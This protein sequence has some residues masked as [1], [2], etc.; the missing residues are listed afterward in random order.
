MKPSI[1]PDTLRSVCRLQQLCGINKAPLQLLGWGQS[2]Q[3]RRH[4]SKRRCQHCDA[5][6]NTQ[7][8]RSDLRV[9]IRG[10]LKRV[11]DQVRFMGKDDQANSTRIHMACHVRLSCVLCMSCMCH[12]CCMCLVCLAYVRACVVC[13]S[14]RVCVVCVCRMSC[15]CMRARVRVC[16]CVFIRM[17]G[18]THALS[19]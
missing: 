15:A 13:D 9:A 16:P 1:H 11:G 8:L 6:K 4:D 17:C 18:I 19:T 10:D 3:L 2:S 12:V 14:Y 7:H 5:K